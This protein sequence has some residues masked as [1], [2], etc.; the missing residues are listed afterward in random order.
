MSVSVEE[1]E[2]LADEVAVLR[3]DMF[4]AGWNAAAAKMPGMAPIAPRK[5]GDTVNGAP[6]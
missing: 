5:P 4:R 1:M 3:A 6:T 2:A